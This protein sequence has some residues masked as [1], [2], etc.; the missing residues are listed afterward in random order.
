MITYVSILV[1]FFILNFISFI[2]GRKK[3]NFLKGIEIDIY[4]YLFILFLLFI[5]A[6]RYGVG[7]D[8]EQYYL[9]IVYNL[10][11]NIVSRG[12]LLTIFLVELSKNF[13]VTNIYFFVNSFITVFLIALVVDKYSQNKW[14]SIL[15]FVS[16]PLFFLNSLSV[17]R[18]F[19]AL[20]IV[21]YSIKYIKEN[22]FLKYIL[23]IYIASLFHGSALLAIALYFFVKQKIGRL[24]IIIY[25]LMAAFSSSI[26]NIL[27]NKHFAEYSVYT[28]KTSVKEGTLAIYFFAFILICS[29]PVIN[30]LNESNSNRIYFNAFFFGFLIY[31]AFFGQGSMSHRLS[32]FGTIF[33]ILLIPKLIELYFENLKLRLIFCYVFYF[34]LS[35]IFIYSV[36][37]GSETYIPYRTIFSL[38]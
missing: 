38:Y 33:S 34:F 9:T 12:E 31:L 35:I 23:A 37:I 25:M 30:R 13:G 3:I 11:T 36:N 28:E 17:I 18:F 10:D 24:K 5:S 19:T 7:W 27:V 16:F 14:I 4:Y 26:L 20:A 21:F 29:F 2:Y 1:I 8:Y 6:F 22:K 32:L 15:I